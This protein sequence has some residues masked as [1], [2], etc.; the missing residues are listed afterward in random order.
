MTYL[1]RYSQV[2]L[3]HQKIKPTYLF[4]AARRSMGAR[5]TEKSQSD[6]IIGT[7]ANRKSGTGLSRN[8]ILGRHLYD[9]TNAQLTWPSKS[10]SA[11]R[12]VAG[13]SGCGKSLKRSQ[14]ELALLINEPVSVLSSHVMSRLYTFPGK[15]VSRFLLSLQRDLIL[16]IT[17]TACYSR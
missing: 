16:I 2:G 9:G 6:L 10:V 7:S 3:S 4:G 12:L 14:E 17:G 13:Q 11:F 1:S 8:S 15:Q 5:H